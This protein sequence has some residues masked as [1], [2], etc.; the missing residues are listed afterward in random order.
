MNREATA[1]GFVI[2]LLLAI[3]AVLFGK[4]ETSKIIIKGADLNASIKVTDPKTLANFF[5]RTGTGT[6]CTGGLLYAKYKELHR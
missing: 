5:V 4:A 3:P 2:L 6:S 1:L